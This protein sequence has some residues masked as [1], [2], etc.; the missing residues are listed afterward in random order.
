MGINLNRK[1]FHEWVRFVFDHPVV[2]NKWYFQ[3]RWRAYGRPPKLLRFATQF[4]EDADVLLRPY[5][6]EQREQG[7]WYLQSVSGLRDWVWDTRWAWPLRRDCIASMVELFKRVYA[8]ENVGLSC[9][10]WWDGMRYFGHDPDP[11]VKDALLEAMSAILAIDSEACWGSAL[12]GLG[13]LDHEGKA[14]VIRGFLQRHPE[15]DG[16]LRSY[17]QAAICGEVL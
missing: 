2:E 12:H 1:S 13:H 9:H 3:R 14:D 15:L 6:D 17:A 11:R 5:R 8:H 16:E 10:M 4:F 7:L